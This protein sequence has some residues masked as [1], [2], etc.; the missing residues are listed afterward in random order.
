VPGR[1]QLGPSAIR[2]ARFAEYCVANDDQV[3]LIAFADRPIATLKPAR[4][5]AAVTRIRE[6]LTGLAPSS[7]E[8][9]VLAAALHVRK[10]VRHRCLVVILTDLYERSATSAVAQ[11]A[12]LLLP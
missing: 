9:D 12:R 10:L 4:G 2:A 11:S 1:Q 8:S 5:V 6:V 7:V 3:G